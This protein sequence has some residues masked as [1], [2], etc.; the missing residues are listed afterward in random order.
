MR[1]RIVTGSRTSPRRKFIVGSLAVHVLV[2]TVL[3]WLPDL[4]GGARIPPNAV[5]VELVGGLPLAPVA[6]AAAPE[7]SPAQ[8]QPPPEGVR[9]E[10]PEPR[11]TE[12]RRPAKP[13]AEPR[14]TPPPRRAPAS[15]AGD[16][17][18]ADATGSAVAGS[19]AAGASV[20]V[21]EGGDAAFAWYRASVTNALYQHWRR[22]ILSGLREPLEVRVAFEIMR[23]GNV[24]GLRTEVSSG[25]PSLDRSALRAISDASP[26]PPLPSTMRD[27][28]LPASFVFRL[29]PEGY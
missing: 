11:P 9:M 23:D 17:G 8:P 20:S 15:A 16:S 28:Y 18:P 27:P 22:P 13:T 12:R 25:V 3:V 29:Y 4:R 2:A 26:L 14:P 24:R 6:A 7:P 19:A 5:V 10:Q 1:I 21:F